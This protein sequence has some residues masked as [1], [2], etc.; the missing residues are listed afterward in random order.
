MAGFAGP[1]GQYKSWVPGAAGAQNPSA[2]DRVGPNYQKFGEQPGWVYYPPTDSYFTDPNYAKDYATQH[3]YG[4][5]KPPGLGATIG[6]IAAASGALAIGQGLGKDPAGFVSGLT[7]LPGKVVSSLS[8]GQAAQVTQTTAPVVQTAAANAPGLIGMGSQYGAGSLTVPT[9]EGAPAAPQIL[10]MTATDASPGMFSLSGIGGAGNVILPAA[11]AAGAFDVLSNNFGNHNLGPG[12]SALEGAASGAALGSYF[13]PPG[14]IVGGGL[15]GL[16]GLGSSLFGDTDEWKQEGNRLKRLGAPQSVID[17]LPTGGRTTSQLTDIARQTG[18]AAD[19]KFAS[20]RNLADLAGHGQSLTG[21]AAFAEADPTGDWW[22][23]PMAERTAIANNALA[24]NAVSEHNG[25][26]DLDPDKAPGLFGL[27]P[28]PPSNN[29]S[30]G[31]R[32][33]K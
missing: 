17:A 32:P 23:R 13:G 16:I 27:A 2:Y 3:G 26:I 28:T 4:P 6:P 7:S 12:R 10:G 20:S 31:R 15:G 29:G 21:Y 19:V 22:G 14:A 9:A 25:T 1:D 8:P 18:D 11:G 5:P 30:P 33:K 24:A